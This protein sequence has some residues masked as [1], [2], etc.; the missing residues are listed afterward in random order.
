MDPPKKRKLEKSYRIFNDDWIHRY[1]FIN[2][3]NKVVCLFCQETVAVIKEYNLKR[4]HQTKDGE[5]AREV[6]QEERRKKSS[7]YVKKLEKQ[8]AVFEKQSVLQTS[9]SQASFMVAYNLARNSKPFSDGE[10]VKTVLGGLCKR[11]V[12][13]NEKQIR[14]HFI[15]KKDY[16]VAHTLNHWGSNR[17][18]EHSKQRLCIV[19]FGNGWEYW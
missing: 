5:F 17:T 3:R 9:A 12:P 6:S 14:H 18:I 8:Q 1:F 15:I 4:H 7:E 13:W 11:S 10:F 2:S 19:F 16:G